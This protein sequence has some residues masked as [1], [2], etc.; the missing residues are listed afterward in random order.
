MK[1]LPAETAEMTLAGFLRDILRMGDDE[2]WEG[3]GVWSNHGGKVVADPS[4]HSGGTGGGEGRSK[5]RTPLLP[6]SVARNVRLKHLCYLWELTFSRTERDWSSGMCP[7]FREK[8]PIN[9]VRDL[10]AA[11]EHMDLRVL[12]PLF[13]VGLGGMGVLGVAAPYGEKQNGVVVVMTTIL[14]LVAMAVVIVMVLLGT[15]MVVMIMMVT[16]DDGV[17][18]WPRPMSGHEHRPLAAIFC[19]MF[20]ADAHHISWVPRQMDR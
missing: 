17:V 20:G 2:G 16:N 1:A 15:M 19:Y 8:L 3:Q 6:P 5:G 18:L 12:L 14:A 11:A 4:V 13:K 7:R 9:L 10:A